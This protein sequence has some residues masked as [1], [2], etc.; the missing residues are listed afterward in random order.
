M[1]NKHQPAGQMS[2]PKKSLP[3]LSLHQQESGHQ[4][5]FTGTLKWHIVQIVHSVQKF[6]LE[7]L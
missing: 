3:V 5:V 2:K 7:M 1:G 4:A 6:G